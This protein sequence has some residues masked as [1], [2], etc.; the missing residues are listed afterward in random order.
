[1]KREGHFKNWEKQQEEKAKAQRGRRQQTQKTQLKKPTKKQTS[2]IKTQNVEE[3]EAKPTYFDLY[4]LKEAMDNFLSIDATSR[5]NIRKQL[6]ENK[7]LIKAE[8]FTSKDNET[9]ELI[10]R[11]VNI[12]GL[13]EAIVNNSNLN[14][15]MDISNESFVGML[16]IFGK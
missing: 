2:L 3:K 12:F 6:R 9:G 16:K 11:E 15:K 7:D 14:I 13:N 8:L 4:P 5:W 1:M 10:E